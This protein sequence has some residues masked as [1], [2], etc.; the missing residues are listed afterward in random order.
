MLIDGLSVEMGSHFVM[1][2]QKWQYPMSRQDMYASGTFTRLMNV[3]RGEGDPQ[4]VPDL[5][6][7]T[8]AD[9]PD[10]TPEE[11]AALTAQLNASSAFGHLRNGD[12][13]G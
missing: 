5:P 13:N 10:V 3:T 9:K 8:E 2:V 1:S 4:F 11:R 12:P 7:E 6:W